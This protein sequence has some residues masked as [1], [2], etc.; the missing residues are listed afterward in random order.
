MP[1]LLKSCAPS[2][3]TVHWFDLS[4]AWDSPTTQSYIILL[5]VLVK[6]LII[7]LIHVLLLMALVSWSVRFW[8]I[9]PLSVL[10]VRLLT[11]VC[12]CVCAC[13]RVCARA[14]VC[15]LFVLLC[16]SADAANKRVHHYR[17]MS[18]SSYRVY[19]VYK[20]TSRR[21]A[22][23]Y[24]IM[25][26]PTTVYLHAFRCMTT[27]KVGWDRCSV[28]QLFLLTISQKLSILG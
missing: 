6:N 8:N 14:F 2:N 19:T 11:V 4:Q 5:C 16:S 12:V 1:T 26:R 25:S 21:L 23:L 22:H 27:C 13:V 3:D 10:H 18:Q 7:W 24:K 20:Y 28:V 9:I 17:L 15:C